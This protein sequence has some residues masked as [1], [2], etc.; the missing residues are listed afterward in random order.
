MNSIHE[1]I[2]FREV[3]GDAEAKPLF[4]NHAVIFLFQIDSLF[5]LMIKSSGTK[6]S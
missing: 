2:I 5:I 1:H 3:S 6:R 4:S